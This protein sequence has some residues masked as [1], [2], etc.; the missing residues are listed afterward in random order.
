MIEC[1][2]NDLPE[3]EICDMLLASAYFPAFR[4]ERLS[5]KLY[6]D[7]GFVDSLPVNVLIEHNCR[8]ILC[9]CLP[10]AGVRA[11]IR[12]PENVSITTI[13]TS[14]DL[15]SIL[16][17]DAARARQNIEIGYYD[18]MRVFYGLEGKIYCVERTLSEEDALNWLIR[19]YRAVHPDV[20]VRTVCEKKL[21]DKAKQL[22]VS[23]G[24]YYDLFIAVLERLAARRKITP[25][26]IYTDKELLDRV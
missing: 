23:K 8:D 19:R 20:S 2:I 11:K 3:N 7:G 22:E 16:E 15:G 18:A 14:A 6:A 9:V 1:R 25:Y 26:A 17:F 5:G 10:G 24:D 21:R 12:K 4:L 13:E